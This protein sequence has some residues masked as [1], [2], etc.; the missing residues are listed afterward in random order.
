MCSGRSDD[1]IREEFGLDAA[2]LRRML[3][4]SVEHLRKKL[5]GLCSHRELRLFDRYR[6]AGAKYEQAGR[7]LYWS[8]K[9]AKR[10][11]ENRTRIIHHTFAA[12]GIGYADNGVRVTH[13]ASRAEIIETLGDRL[14]IA[15]ERKNT[16]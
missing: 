6:S 13:K 12:R 11:D 16:Q 8:G 14:L 9:K 15:L 2:D 1:E 4:P 5:H 3:A 7:M 10:V